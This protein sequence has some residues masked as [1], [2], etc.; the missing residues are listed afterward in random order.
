MDFDK[1]LLETSPACSKMTNLFFPLPGHSSKAAAAKAI[2]ATC[3]ILIPCRNYALQNKIR[4]GIWGGLY[5]QERRKVLRDQARL[6]MVPLP[7]PQPGE[8][9]WLAG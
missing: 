5:E 8:I 9:R 6:R 7:D 3:P 2:C 1:L 4:H